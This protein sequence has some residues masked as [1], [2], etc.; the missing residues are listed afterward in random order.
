MH[1]KRGRSVHEKKGIDYNMVRKYNIE[2][3]VSV[4]G[5]CNAGVV[6]KREL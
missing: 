5:N 1:P 6:K 3:W 4:A 2:L